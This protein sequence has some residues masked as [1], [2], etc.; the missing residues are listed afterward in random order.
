LKL[1]YACALSGTLL[2]THVMPDANF[3][4]KITITATKRN[5]VGSSDQRTAYVS[6]QSELSLID[7]DFASLTCASSFR[8]IFYNL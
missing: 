6:T 7:M 4:T 3:F 1:I 8:M 5:V 2:M